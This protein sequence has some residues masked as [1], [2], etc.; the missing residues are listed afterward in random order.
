MWTLQVI[1][2]SWLGTMTQGVQKSVKMAVGGENGL[3]TL[4]SSYSVREDEGRI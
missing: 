1:G 2:R 3:N 4:L